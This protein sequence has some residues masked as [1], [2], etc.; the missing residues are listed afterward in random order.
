MVRIPGGEFFMGSDRVNADQQEKPAHKATVTAFYID[1]TEVTCEDYQNF[2]K[3]TGHKAPAKWLGGS[4]PSGDVRKPVT[5]VDWYDA[6]AYAKWANKRLPTEEEWEFAARGI[7]GRRYPWG[8]EWKDEAANAATTA[9]KHLAEVGEHKEGASP[10][11]AF[12]M[13]GNAW[14]WTA[15]KLVPYPG[16]RL[17]QEASEDLRVIRGGSWQSDKDSATTTYRFGWPASGGKD[18]DNTSFRCARDV[19]QP[20]PAPVGSR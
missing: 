16:G 14:E 2:V 11:G 10:F 18:Y 6:S 3:A 13:V 19:T 20:E 7:D 17:A 9:H 5:G 15:S 1:A 12:D 8:N 4:C